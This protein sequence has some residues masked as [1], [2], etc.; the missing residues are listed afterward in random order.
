MLYVRNLMLCTT[1]DTLQFMFSKAGG[2]D[3]CVQRVKKNNDYAFIHFR[4]REEAMLAMERTDGM[5][6]L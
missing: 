6:C 2:D 5:Y 4:S 3:D 1:E